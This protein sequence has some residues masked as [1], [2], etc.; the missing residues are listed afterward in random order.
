MASPGE[1]SCKVMKRV[2][3]I[4]P[5]GM[6]RQTQ[7]PP[8][9]CKHT[10]GAQSKPQG[11]STHQP[12]FGLPGYLPVSVYGVLMCT[13]HA[14]S[15]AHT[16][17]QLNILPGMLSSAKLLCCCLR[18]VL[19]R[20]T[21]SPYTTTLCR[22]GTR[23]PAAGQAHA[24]QLSMLKVVSTGQHSW[25]IFGQTGVTPQALPGEATSN[26]PTQT[27]NDVHGPMTAVV[28]SL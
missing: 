26:S 24:C 27:K 22:A 9:V 28:L 16:V 2:P 12:S 7:K 8:L 3:F 20:G 11:G 4:P 17:S 23:L 14:L 21:P 25:N 13:P 6:H 15:T 19:C 1:A 5:C 10:K 18:S